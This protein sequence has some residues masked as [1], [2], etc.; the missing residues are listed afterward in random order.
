MN[1]APSDSEKSSES[2]AT[3]DDLKWRFMPHVWTGRYIKWFYYV[4][5]DE[6]V[7]V[8]CWP[9][10]GRMAAID[11]TGREWWPKDKPVVSL[12]PPEEARFRAYNPSSIREAY[13]E[14]REEIIQEAFDRLQTKP[15]CKTSARGEKMKLMRSRAKRQRYLERKR[16]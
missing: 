7:R 10:A 13:E 9:N 2:P 15:P 5:L 12:Q 11:G 1:D 16:R 4:H 14:I 8:L 3:P 6:G